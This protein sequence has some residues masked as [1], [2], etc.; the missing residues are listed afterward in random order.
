MPQ[1]KMANPQ[2]RTMSTLFI[3]SYNFGF[4]EITDLKKYFW[5]GLESTV[6]TCGG[7]L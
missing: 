1:S 7:N 4:S 5:I 2:R 3:S 6:K